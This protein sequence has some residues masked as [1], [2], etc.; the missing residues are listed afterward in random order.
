MA[1]IQRNAFLYLEPPPDF[2]GADFAQCSA[3]KMLTCAP[4]WNVCS[5][6]GTGV[7]IAEPSDI[8][9]GVYSYGN[10]RPDE[11]EHATAAFTP[12]TSGMVRRQVRC[13]NCQF[14][15]EKQLRCGLYQLLNRTLPGLFDLDEN[16][17]ARACCNAQEPKGDYR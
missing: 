3:C 1:K 14:F 2:H 5:L 16:V 13:E 6:H 12:E 8:S 7:D 15:M 11:I 4:A 10:Q 9:C 17:M